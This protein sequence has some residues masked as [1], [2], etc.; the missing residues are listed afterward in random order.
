M[1]FQTISSINYGQSNERKHDRFILFQTHRCYK[2]YPREIQTHHEQTYV[3]K[4][5]TFGMRLFTWRPCGRKHISSSAH[6]RSSCETWS[7]S[8]CENATFFFL[9]DFLVDEGSILKGNSVNNESQHQLISVCFNLPAKV[10]GSLLP[11]GIG[12]LKLYVTK[13]LHSPPQRLSIFRNFH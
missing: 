1:S 2:C 10:H 13:N 7:L 5:S 3:L 4:S 8:T 11:S 12:L 9:T 6:F